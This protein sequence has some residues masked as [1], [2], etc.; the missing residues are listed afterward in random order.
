MVLRLPELANKLVGKEV[1]TT[2]PIAT[3]SQVALAGER[4]PSRMS[5]Y[6]E[7]PNSP[8]KGSL[9]RVHIPRA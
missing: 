6:Y 8:G 7:R 5:S 2:K 3:C 4:L 9:L 1:A